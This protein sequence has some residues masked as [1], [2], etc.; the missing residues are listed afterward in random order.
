MTDQPASPNCR[1]DDHARCWACGCQCHTVPMP[2]GFRD[3]VRSW[4]SQGHDAED[5]TP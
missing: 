3:Q 2:P 5:D 4:T 1:R